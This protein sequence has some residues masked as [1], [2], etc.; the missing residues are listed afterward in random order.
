LPS[1]DRKE[2]V[3]DDA[4]PLI[5]LA[6]LDLLSCLPVVIGSILVP[7]TVRGECLRG[8]IRSDEQTLV[9]AL[10]RRGL[11]EV[12]PD[13]SRPEIVVREM[14]AGEASVLSVA[15]DR[16]CGVIMDDR[17]G[18]RSAVELGI[19]VIG[20]VGI[21]VLAKRRGLLN[22]ISTRL[23]YLVESGYHLSD[24]LRESAL[25]AAGER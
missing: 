19:P 1:S 24:A 2:V 22:E 9:A 14:D 11:L 17:R 7:E 10:G 6:R 23:D 12:M 18:R 20:T 3:A 16:H 4:G 21:L 25:R 8:A 15:L 13:A 5:A